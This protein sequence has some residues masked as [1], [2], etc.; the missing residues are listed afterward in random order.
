MIL[1]DFSKI[2]HWESAGEKVNFQII[3]VL[4]WRVH[5]KAVWLYI[6]IVVPEKK[7]MSLFLGGGGRADVNRQKLTKEIKV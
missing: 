5:K 6:S 3:A 2:A 1:V 4:N 7:F